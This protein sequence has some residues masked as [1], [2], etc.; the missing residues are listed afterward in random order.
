MHHHHLKNQLKS[1][2]LCLLGMGGALLLLAFADQGVLPDAQQSPQKLEVKKNF[3]RYP[4]YFPYQKVAEE[5]Y[6]ELLKEKEKEKPKTSEE[7]GPP[8]S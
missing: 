1:G 8:P 3:P 4:V 7:P 2:F 5:V 6:E